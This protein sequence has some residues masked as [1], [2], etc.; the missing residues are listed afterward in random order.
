MTELAKALRLPFSTAMDRARF[1]A[2]AS[3]VI[4]T[5][6]L[7]RGVGLS[8]LGWLVMSD[9]RGLELASALAPTATIALFGCLALWAVARERR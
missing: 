1:I 9:D 4:V 8:V 6:L 5:L 3:L 2:L 7:C